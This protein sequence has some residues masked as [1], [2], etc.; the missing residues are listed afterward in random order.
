MQQHETA[1][2]KNGKA[3]MHYLA[4][5]TD[6]DG[7]IACEGRVEPEV[8]AAL[9]RVA[10][11]GRRLVM[12]TGRELGEVLALYPHV[13]IFDRLVVE[14]GAL[15]YTPATKTSRTLSPAPPPEMIAEFERRDIPCS[16]G[17]TIVA[18]IEPYQHAVLSVIHDL[19]LEWH[20]IFN[21][22]AVMVLPSGVNK[23][24]GLSAALKELD[25]EPDRVAA[26]GD[27]E[28]DHALLRFCGCG[29]AVA[30]ALPAL[31]TSADVVL[32]GAIGAG[33]IELVRSLIDEDLACYPLRPAAHQPRPAA[34]SQPSA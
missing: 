34:A 13:D 33:V 12:V 27:A 31:K 32:Q 10:A 8:T 15:L 4:L 3:P 23:A 6:F 21:K 19:G 1:P 16:V 29:A 22:G 28:N 14:N 2:G 24:S 20:V 30:N 9:R 11:T 7:T 25:V 5:A 26:V 17:R 18:T